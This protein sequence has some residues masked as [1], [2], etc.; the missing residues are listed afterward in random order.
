MESK[1]GYIT[2]SKTTFSDGLPKKEV[3]EKT[4]QI[5]PFE[6][7]PAEVEVAGSLTIPTG[8]WSSAKIYVS[9]KVP[10]YKEEIVSVYKQV[11]GLV[12]R[13]LNKKAAQIKKEMEIN[14]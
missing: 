6:T 2:V 3:E 14:E 11:D 1:K 13:I 10:C 5:K 7:T 12:D 8:N 4:L 9:I